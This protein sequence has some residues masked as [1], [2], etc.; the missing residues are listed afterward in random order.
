MNTTNSTINRRVSAK[1]SRMTVEEAQTLLASLNH[2]TINQPVI[3]E[4]TGGYV[5]Q[6]L[7]FSVARKLGIKAGYI[8]NF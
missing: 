8:R 3:R 1:I 5:S 7:N 2:G 4:L 6:N